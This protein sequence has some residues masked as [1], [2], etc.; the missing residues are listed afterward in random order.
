MSRHTIARIFFV[1]LAFSL[2]IPVIGR[3]QPRVDNPAR[4]LAKNA[5]RIVKLEEILRI[6]DDGE[7][8]IFKVPRNLVCGSDGSLYFMDYGDGPR[9]YRYG[10]EGKLISKLLRTGQ[11]PGEAQNASNFL[12]T[13]DRIR[14]LAWIPPK[15]MDLGMDGRYLRETRVE[16]DTHG[17]W[18]L[19]MA[20]GRIYG[21]RDEL[22][23]S[24]AF[25]SSGAFTAFSVP[26]SV[27]EISPDFRT[28]RKLYEFPVRMMVK[29]GNGF[30]LD[31]I[32]ATIGESTLYLLHTAEYQVVAFDLRAG[33]VKHVVSR[34]YA[35]VRSKPQKSSDPDPD[36]ETR[37]LDF[38]DETYVWDAHKIHAAAG[39]LWVFT[40][41]A[42]ADGDDQQ[43]DLFDE[44]GRFVDSVILR[45]P[46]GNRDHRARWTLL[47]DD[48]YFIIPEQEEDG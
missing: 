40:S 9:L 27:Y 47:T 5:G 30:R 34:A 29:R 28:W 48:G 42:K 43:V 46:P 6:R 7:K 36:P 31:P 33:R 38:P 3:T 41:V 24:A 39:R 18:F 23:S 25:R 15:I 8:A 17:L 22:F 32:D 10:P 35:R 21:I 26:N 45:F 44:A 37:G 4:A 11:G 12:V 14:V 1:C 19:G 16:E 2:G 20:E 13:G